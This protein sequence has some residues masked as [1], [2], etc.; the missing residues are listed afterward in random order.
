MSR[1]QIIHSGHFMVSEP[2]AE[3]DPDPDPDPNSEA[4][5]S[6]AGQASARLPQ[7]GPCMG[8]HGQRRTGSGWKAAAGKALDGAQQGCGATYDFVTVDESTC[9][10]YRYGPR[11]SGALN[12]DSSLTKLFECMTLAYSGKL[13]SPKWKNFK[14]LKLLQ[15]D[16]I[17]LNN[18]IWRAWYLQYVEKGQNPVC[19][20]VAPL[21]CSDIDEHRR[22]EAIIMEEKYWK[23]QIGVV[24]RE[25]R[26]WRTFYH[27]RVKKKMNKPVCGLTQEAG[28][29]IPGL[30]LNGGTASG[31]PVELDPLHELNAILGTIF[32]SRTPFGGPNLRGLDHQGNADMIQPTLTQLQPFFGE[33]FMDTMD[34]IHELITTCHSQPTVQALAPLTD[35][36]ALGLCGSDVS[37][38]V[39]GAKELLPEDAF[40][41]VP[42]SLDVEPPPPLNGQQ[43]FL[44]FFPTSPWSIS[45]PPPAPPVLHIQPQTSLVF[46]VITHTGPGNKPSVSSPAGTF[47]VP[48]S[49]PTA[50]SGRCRH[51]QRIAPA[52]SSGCQPGPPSAFLTH[53]L[54]TGTCL[55]GW[56][57]YRSQWGGAATGS[58]N[59]LYLDLTCSPALLP[60]L[61]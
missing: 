9:L 21:E 54:T 3:L 16:K 19:S 26:R 46:S 40:L 34:P 25:Y 50:K 43:T 55:L 61:L 30:E 59:I 23:C 2:H 42:I 58:S 37:P 28:G 7:P 31:N 8:E 56:A 52:P 53:L 6:P 57:L 41:P 60:W 45:P 32:S 51:L 38:A 20:F 12:I 44:P 48:S 27:T 5:M 1:P 14:G 35:A 15:R 33:E 36:A 18:A 4:A 47:A 24:G 13:V 17:R 29:C 10:I 49:A 22:P 11:S 39:P